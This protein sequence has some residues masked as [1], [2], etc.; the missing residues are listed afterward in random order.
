MRSIISILILPFTVILLSCTVGPDYEPPEMGAPDKFV[1]QEVLDKMN[2]QSG[3]KG[4]GDLPLNWWEGFSDPLLNQLVENG[5]NNN[6]RIASATARLRQAR[7]N[8]ELAG[9]GDE[10]STVASVETDAEEELD[11]EDGDTNF[12]SGLL[13]SLSLVLPLD[14]FGRVTR[15][16]E[17]ALA[18]LEGARADLR[19]TILEISS[20]IVRNYLT[21]RGNQR[22][23]D[24]LEQS[25]QLQDKTLSIV[26]SRYEAGLS[27]ELDVRRAEATVENLRA[28]IPELRQSLVNSRNTLANLTGNYP[29]TYE[30]MLKGDENIPEYTAVV[31]DLVPAQVLSMRP[32]VQQ[33]EAELKQAVAGI[34]VAKAE[35][36]PFF[37]LIGQISIGSGGISGEPTMDLL[38]GSIAA[39][40]EQVVTDGGARRANLEIAKAQ[41]EEALSDYRQ[42]LL[43]AMQEVED[44]LSALESSL[45]RQKSLEKA[46]SASER[47]FHQAG[48]LYTQGLTSFLD[49][50][51]A[52]R[53]L[54]SAQQDLAAARTEY[55]SQV[56]NLFRVLGTDIKSHSVNN[57][58]K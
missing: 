48:I 7:A 12:D 21:L 36:Y 54:A 46:V 32:D 26:R 57:N 28:D 33:A 11:L 43:D 25:V 20:D 34:G 9:A 23:L 52:Q 39:L 29:G 5:I 35:F 45:N 40:I 17:A 4:S 27:P 51:D 50:V 10:L 56:A 24:L 19:G 15:Q 42:T 6:Y 49:V 38:I 14:V 13:G 58:S 37:Q 30:E 44:T 41:A 16:E 18:Q 55:A 1:L 47:S 2:E 22:Q 31:P 3:T 8:L 53:T